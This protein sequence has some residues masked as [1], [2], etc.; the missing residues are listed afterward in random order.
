MIVIICLL[1]NALVNLS[2]LTPVFVLDEAECE[3]TYAFLPM[4]IFLSYVASFSSMSLPIFGKQYLAV[5]R[6][7]TAI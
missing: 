2:S 6:L 3:E 7:T 5:I 1:S 4:T